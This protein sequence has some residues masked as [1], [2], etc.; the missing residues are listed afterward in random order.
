MKGIIVVMAT[1]NAPYCN[2]ITSTKV[3]GRY[4]IARIEIADVIII[5]IFLSLPKMSFRFRTVYTTKKTIRKMIIFAKNSSSK[6]SRSNRT[7]DMN[8]ITIVIIS[9][10]PS[11]NCSRPSTGPA[12]ASDDR[13]IVRNAKIPPFLFML[14][15]DC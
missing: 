2:R 1:A 5:V 10:A 4:L 15:L 6:D 9:L 14:E 7:S 8:W 13:N 3:V 11:A 12:D